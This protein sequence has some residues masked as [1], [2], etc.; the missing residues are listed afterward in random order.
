M[1]LLYFFF[2]SLLYS[3]HN[4]SLV[5]VKDDTKWVLISFFAG[6]IFHTLYILSTSEFPYSSKVAKYAIN[7]G[8]NL[9]ISCLNYFNFNDF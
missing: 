1:K 8:F 5:K 6:L 3:I 9:F 2:I 4:K 7:G